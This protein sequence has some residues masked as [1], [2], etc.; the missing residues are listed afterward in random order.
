VYIT[1][2]QIFVHSKNKSKAQSTFQKQTLYTAKIIRKYISWLVG[3]RARRPRDQSP[4]D[5]RPKNFFTTTRRSGSQKNFTPTLHENYTIS[6]EN[7]T[8][9][10]NAENVIYYY[11]S[12]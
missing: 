8:Q 1:I 6:H 4:G 10:E 2:A 12:M 11:Y 7:H 9:C 3:R 5:P